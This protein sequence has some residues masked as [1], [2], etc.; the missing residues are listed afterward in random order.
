MIDSWEEL[1]WTLFPEADAESVIDRIH[2]SLAKQR[3]DIPTGGYGI[4]RSIENNTNLRAGPGTDHAIVGKTVRDQTYV[5]LGV[6]QGWLRVQLP[7]LGDA[8]ISM[9]KVEFSPAPSP[10]AAPREYG[11]SIAEFMTASA[12]TVP[13]ASEKSDVLQYKFR[14]EMNARQDAVKVASQSISPTALDGQVSSNQ[15]M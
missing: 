13:P 12:Q 7:D 8:W 15:P 4:A 9:K 1:V 2:P 10:S 6:G 5:V 11:P 3:S 14:D